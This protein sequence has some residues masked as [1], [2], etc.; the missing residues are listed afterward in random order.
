MTY[1]SPQKNGFEERVI[2]YALS[3]TGAPFR[4]H[5]KLHTS[6]LRQM[7]LTGES[8]LEHGHLEVGP[9][10]GFDCSGFVQHVFEGSIGVYLPR[11][12]I[13]MFCSVE[14]GYIGKTALREVGLDEIR[15]AEL[16]FFRGHNPIIP[17]HVAIYSGNGEIA[18]SSRRTNG[19]AVTPLEEMLPGLL[20][21]KRVEYA[22]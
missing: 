9:E 8:Y 2:R 17:T 10:N 7:D 14:R 1:A 13:E 12:T 3:L 16:L 20:A 21:V 18:H 19:V 11:H 22:R 4:P 6:R 15:G 5:V